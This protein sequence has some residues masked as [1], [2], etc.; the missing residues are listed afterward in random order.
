[1]L[2]VRVG[3][4]FLAGW[5]HFYA[6]IC[7]QR[8]YSSLTVCGSVVFSSFNALFLYVITRRSGPFFVYVL[9]FILS[10]SGCLFLPRLC[11]YFLRKIPP[12]LE[13]IVV[14]LK[15]DSMRGPREA[16]GVHEQGQRHSRLSQIFYSIILV[17]ILT[18]G[19]Y[20]RFKCFFNTSISLW[21]DEANVVIWFL[22]HGLFYTIFEEIPNR[23]IGYMFLSFFLTK[24]YNIDW[25]IKL[26]SLVPSVLSLGV[27]YLLSRR[28]FQSRLMQLVAVFMASINPQLIFFGNEFKPY[29][30]EFFFHLLTLYATVKYIQEGSR[31]S[32]G[33]ALSSCFLSLFFT[34]NIMSALASVM[35]VLSMISLREKK[36]NHLFVILLSSLLFLAYLA[37]IAGFLWSHIEAGTMETASY[38]GNKYGTFYVGDYLLGHLWWYVQKTGGLIYKSLESTTF[39]FQPIHWVSILTLTYSL[40]YI[41]GL[42]LYAKRGEYEY[43]ALFLLPVLVAVLF[44]FLNLMPYGPDRV[45]LYL[46]AYFPMLVFLPI[47]SAY[48][49]RRKALKILLPAA[50]VVFFLVL[51]FPYQP[52][53]FKYKL[54]WSTQTFTKQAIRYI[55]E[56]DKKETSQAICLSAPAIRAFNYY[57]RFARGY[58]EKYGRD[59]F[60]DFQIYEMWAQEAQEVS[61]FIKEIL[62]SNRVVY[63][64]LANPS[65]KEDER[66][67]VDSLSRYSTRMRTH[68]LEDSYPIGAVREKIFYAESLI[69]RG[70]G[71]RVG[72]TE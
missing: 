65:T 32:L 70:Q 41:M 63:V 5:S 48:A 3:S 42:V 17:M 45:N 6:S 9:V 31:A 16:L 33:L 4:F 55:H 8:G 69:Y 50:V 27:V 64:Y 25:M 68:L 10:A 59:L 19:C 62:A 12:F 34:L 22:K 61:K 52:G 11:K 26:P 58:S 54:H 53:S 43:L 72:G 66:R 40:L 36:Y 7:Q 39:L 18:I 47:D 56:N 29:A 51:P 15:L 23:P 20:L 13:G 24:T 2:K 57:A 35:L 37:L 21:A 49:I 38:Y 30:L 67:I 60:R 46:F 28:M 1:M 14:H 71:K 44:N